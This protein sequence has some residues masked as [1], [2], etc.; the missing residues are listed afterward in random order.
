[1]NFNKIIWLVLLLFVPFSSYCEDIKE[2]SKADSLYVRG[3]EE[4]LKKSFNKARYYFYQASLINDSIKRKEPYYS[5]NS[6]QWEASVL[7]HLGDTLSA[8]N[9]STECMLTPVD[10]R[11]TIVSDSLWAVSDMAY[12]NGDLEHAINAA[13]NAITNEKTILGT[14]HYYVANSYVG[15]SDIYIEK[16][17]VNKAKKLLLLA[18]DIFEKS[19]NPPTDNCINSY[20]TISN[21]YSKNKNY[22]KAIDYCLSAKSLINNFCNLG[23]NAKINHELSKIYDSIEDFSKAYNYTLE[24]ISNL[25][26]LKLVPANLYAECK[27]NAGMYALQIFNDSVLFSKYMQEA[28]SLKEKI[29]GRTQNYYW[30]MECYA[31]GYYYLAEREKFP[32]NI[33]LLE[34]SM[35][36]YEMIPNHELIENYRTT[37]NNLAHFYDGVNIDKSIDLCQKLLYIEK[38][39]GVGDTILTLSNLAEYYKDVDYKKALY[40]ANVVLSARE[41]LPSPDLEKIRLSHYKLATVY[42]RGNE[43]DKAIYHAQKA[44]ELAKT[45]YGTNSEKYATALQNLGVYFSLNRDTLSSLEYTRLAYINPFGDKGSIANNLAGVYSQMNFPDSCYKYGKESWEIACSD[46]VYNIVNL[47]KENRYDY[48]C[49]PKNFGLIIQPMNIMLCHENHENIRKL[50]FDSAL[51]SKNILKKCMTLNERSFFTRDT[52][53]SVKSYLNEGEVAIEIWENKEDIF[54]NGDNLLAFIIRNDY[55]S[56]KLVKLSKDKIIRTFRNEYPMT[57][58]SLPMYDNIWKEIIEVAKIQ[59]GEKIYI[60]L[61]GYLENLQFPVEIIMGYDGEFVGDKY[62][63][64]RVSSTSEISNMKNLKEVKNAVLYGGLKYDSNVMTIADKSLAIYKGTR[65]IDEN[66]F[67]EMTDTVF[68]ELRSTTKYLPWTKMEVDTVSN[69]LKKSLKNDVIVYEGDN[70]IEESF[71]ALSGNSPSILHIATHGYIGQSKE[72]PN[73]LWEI[74]EYFME[75]TGLLFS[76]VLNTASINKETLF[77]EDGILRSS[78]ISTLD[79]SNTKLL[80]LSACNTGLGGSSPLGNIGL[81][82]AFK[83]AGVGTILMTLNDVDDSACF[84]MMKYFYNFITAGYSKREAFKKAKNMLRESE[85]YQDFSYWGAFVM[86]D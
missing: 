85:E 50:A 47:S 65:S 13:L 7:Y 81:A 15:L 70:G 11:Q 66:L 49:T 19:G 79:L 2:E 56:P 78:E 69:Y 55:D 21:L 18:I 31:H 64:I 20:I 35:G 43:F 80:V 26:S 45:I 82:R 33:S 77:I 25:D 38:K 17:D 24:A 63:I 62:N 44:L 29:E 23:Y 4:Y 30:T 14:N 46:F 86:I 3:I 54:S 8:Y 60:S 68:S 5:S 59:D 41:S 10:Q 58:T 76:G 83:V 36:I 9:L 39:C 51:F 34:R 6:A 71:K 12:E 40:Y 74:Y 75:N 42:C 84:Y 73:S 72:I 57:E 27:H 37:L 52:F 48:I 22:K 61:D 67:E 53:D 1:M 16:G 28:M 32:R